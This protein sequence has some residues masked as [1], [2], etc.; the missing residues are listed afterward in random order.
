MESNMHY[1]R[2]I[3]RYYLFSISNILAAFGGGLI[4]GKATDVIMNPALHGG[5]ILAFL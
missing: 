1:G 5:S 2:T 3:S 4:L